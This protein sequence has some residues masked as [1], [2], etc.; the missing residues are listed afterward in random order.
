MEIELPWFYNNQ[1]ILAASDSNE[2]WSERVRKTLEWYHESL[3]RSITGKLLR[4][5]NQWSVEDLIQRSI[6]TLTNA[7]VIDRRLKELPTSARVLLGII[8]IS[9]QP[10]WRVSQL[11]PILATLGYSEGLVPFRILFDNGLIYPN[12]SNSQEPLKQFDDFFGGEAFQFAEIFVHPSVAQRSKEEE[13][14]L[15]KLPSHEISDRGVRLS[16]GFEWLIRSAVIWQQLANSP[17]R[18][19]QKQLFSKRDLTRFQNEELLK[20]PFAEQFGEVPDHSILGIYLALSTNVIEWVDGELRPRQFDREW[21]IG[22]EEVL[23]VHAIALWKIDRWDPQKGYHPVDEGTSFPSLSFLTLL[24]LNHQPKSNWILA[25]DLAEFLWNHHPAW[26]SSLRQKEGDPESWMKTFLLGV[27]YQLRLVEINQSQNQFYFRLSEF[28]RAFWSGNS[29]PKMASEFP[30]TLIVQPN[31]EVIVFRHGLTP[32][33]LNR[34]TRFANWK[35]LGTALTFELNAESIYRGLE[36]GLSFQ[37]I[38]K[39]LQ[40]HSTKNVPANIIDSIQRWSNKRE[41]I[42]VYTSATLV[43][44]SSPQE[45][46]SAF[47]RGLLSLKL[48]DRIGLIESGEPEYKHFRLVGN[49]D[50]EAKPQKCISFDP[51]GV[52]FTIDSALSDLVLEAE[53]TRFAEPR[54]SADSGHRRFAFTRQSLKKAAEQGITLLELEEWCFNRSGEPIS[55]SAHM[56][57]SGSGGL[58]GEMRRCLV[59]QLPTEILTD[60]LMQYPLT[61]ECID[62]RLGSCALAIYEEKREIF[63][64]R[65]SEL[66]IQFKNR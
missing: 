57:F 37:E 20:I 25:S 53:L 7:V 56:L 21:E 65:L 12:H 16:D 35:T 59:F 14:Q 39:Y 54:S 29:L 52:T 41:R 38:I 22:L 63:E 64:Q 26:K 23:R 43:E 24:L 19:T 6:E 45:M 11:V 4:P 62:E 50:Y 27:A 58:S 46:E 13:F 49:R 3:L 34:L 30:Q 31:S 9:Q 28:G 18:L 5:R 40:Q 1:M 36:T 33:L 32:S 17:V 44:F 55:S 61:A 2:I 47:T 10:I 8:G 66:G 42:T 51:D 60:G 15:P 48:T